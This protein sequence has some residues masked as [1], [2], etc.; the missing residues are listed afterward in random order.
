M[1]ALW[2]LA[3]VPSAHSSQWLD[4]GE[5]LPL[6][7]NSLDNGGVTGKFPRRQPKNVETSVEAM[8]VRLPQNVCPCREESWSVKGSL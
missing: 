8:E 7:R 5:I 6:F 2:A 1:R 3:C 4:T